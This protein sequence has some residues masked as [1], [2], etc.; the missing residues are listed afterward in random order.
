MATLKIVLRDNKKPNRAGEYPVHIRITHQRMVRY[1]ALP[2]RFQLKHWNKKESKL[3]TSHPRYAQYNVEINRIYQE[4]RQKMDFLMLDNPHAT[5]DQIREVLD[6]KKKPKDFI[7][8]SYEIIQG[9]YDEERVRYANRCKHVID[10]LSLFTG[11]SLPFKDMDVSFLRRYKTWL[12]RERKN[13]QNTVYGNFKVMKTFYKQAIAEG[14]TTLGDNPFFV[15]SV[16]TEEVHKD[17]LELKHIKALMAIEFEGRL[18]DPVYRLT[19]D[20]FLFSFWCAGIRFSDLANLR[21][22]N[23]TDGDT[24]DYVMG[25]TKAS[26]GS[27]KVIHLSPAAMGIL[28]QYSGKVKSI[29]GRIFPW[30]IEP[31]ADPKLRVKLVGRANARAN[32]ALKVLAGHI[33]FTGNL[34]FHTSRHSFTSIADEVADLSVKELQSLLGHSDSRTT[35]IYRNSLSKGRDK[36]A[37]AKFYEALRQS[38]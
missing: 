23:I 1:I 2:F 13:S 34:T 25:K 31:T 18:E 7:S 27:R 17:H 37:M 33:G 16:K 14:L 4:Y 6:P 21:W 9:F 29:D 35:E 24:L 38:V 22:K 11:G 8:F 28:S 5:I 32:K 36:Q 20:S 30:D 26:K 3:R 19:R 15:F 10:K 12:I